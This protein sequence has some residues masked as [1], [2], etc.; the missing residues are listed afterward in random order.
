MNGYENI[1]SKK[2]TNQN[3]ANNLGSNKYVMPGLFS[4][5][6]KDEDQ[7]EELAKNKLYIQGFIAVLTAILTY[8]LLKVIYK[9]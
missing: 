3:K 8:I 1:F 2:Y 9:V 6:G 5:L 4:Y 7:E